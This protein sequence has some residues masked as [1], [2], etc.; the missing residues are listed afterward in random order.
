MQI[1]LRK[2]Q[3][4]AIA[5]LDDEFRKGNRRVILWALMGSGKTTMA[6]WMIKR[7][8]HYNFPVIF[9][10]RGRELVKNASEVLDRYSI[11]HSINMAGH[12]RYDQK[13]IVQ[14]CSVDTLKSRNNYPF[15]DQEPLIFLDEAH[16][17]YT[18]IFEVYP[19]AFII[20]M[21]GTPFTDMSKYYSYV[22][23]IEGYELRDQGHL[24]PEKIYCPHIIDV[25]A[26][27]VKAGDFEK[28]QL[29]SIV[30]QG[31][32]VGNVVQD[33]IRY[34]DDRPTVCFAVS[35]EH[36]L[37][38]SHAFNDIGISSVHCDANSNDKERKSAKEGLENGSIK[39]VCNVDI[40]SVGWD[41]PIVSCIILARPTWSLTW[42]LQAIGRGLRPY[43][44]KTDCIILDNAGNVFRH[45][46]PYRM[47]EI[48]LDKPDKKKKREMDNKV[49]T[50]EECF[51]VFDPVIH[52][53]CP[54]CGWQKPKQIRI[55]KEMDGSLV[56][57]EESDKEAEERLY[58]MM[59]NDYYKL[60]WVRKTKKLNE[61]FTFINLKKKYPTVFHLLVKVTVVPKA[62]LPD[63]RVLPS[64]ECQL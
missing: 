36:S 32:V 37:Q 42:Y 34:G 4:L 58:G 43:R 3:E 45:G 7:A 23:P 48:S 29:N 35:V 52:E 31:S 8:V 27:K 40:F 33:W 64:L 20:G 5:Q 30:T 11:S 21:T 6:A 10:V 19:Q 54:E 38:L 46:T 1:G 47:R 16:K 50:C 9:I 49:C 12:W 51:Y 62:F 18:D 59:R 60:E 55:V 63:Q 22:H 44:K 39:V 56:Q 24:V 14:V 41:C 2:Y 25:S 57:Y 15:K 17:D 13:K 28:K 26:V 61:N 53:A